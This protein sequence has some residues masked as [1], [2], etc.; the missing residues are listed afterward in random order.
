MLEMLQ[1]VT[2]GNRICLLHTN[3]SQEQP[4]V[5][6]IQ[7]TARHENKSLADEM[8]SLDNNIHVPYLFVGIKLDSWAQCLM[9]WADEAVSHDEEVGRHA[10]DTLCYIENH[11]LPWLNERIGK[12]P[13]VIGG[14]SLG[15]LFA[16]WAAYLSNLFNGVA[17][18][19]P[20]VWIKNWISFA[21]CNV[22]KTSSVYLSLGY[23]EEHARNKRMAAVGEC[24]RC[25]H[26][27]LLDQ[28]TSSHTTLEWNEGEHFNDEATRMARGFIWSYSCL[29]NTNTL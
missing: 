26:E 3:K 1:S 6:F 27:L 21:E 4:V 7:P 23:R 5:V 9:P 20:S 17:A 12:V 11:L 28:I 8:I 15:G 16:L 14:Y 29:F 18:V 10:V 13:C 22:M 19:S 25:Q 24:I 2:I